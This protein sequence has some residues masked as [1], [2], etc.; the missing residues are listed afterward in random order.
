[1]SHPCHGQGGPERLSGRPGVLQPFQSR[2]G[3][4]LLGLGTLVVLSPRL[5][6]SAVARLSPSGGVRYPDACAL[7]HPQ[8]RMG[9]GGGCPH[10]ASFLGLVGGGPGAKAPPPH[11]M[12]VQGVLTCLSSFSFLPVPRR[13]G[14]KIYGNG[15][16]RLWP[17]GP[18]HAL[19]FGRMERK[20][21]VDCL[22]S[23]DGWPVIV[24]PVAL[25][26]GDSAP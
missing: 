8:A 6:P 9:F 7:A 23:Q 10:E 22:V 12:A 4:G 16:C 2:A 20:S 17:T 11:P 21:M 14:L 19:A 24:L 18:P 25:G 3:A 5:C 15:K 13:R 26:L 1:M